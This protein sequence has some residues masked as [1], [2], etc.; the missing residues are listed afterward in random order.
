MTRV[1]SEMYPLES[2]SLLFYSWNNKER[3]QPRGN[4]SKTTE[5]YRR[6][7][8]FLEIVTRPERM[9]TDLEINFLVSDSH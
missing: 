4:L 3:V 8:L 2:P 9:E 1:E 7:R 5:S 6:N